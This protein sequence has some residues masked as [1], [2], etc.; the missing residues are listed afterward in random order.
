MPE[1]RV[2]VNLDNLTLGDFT[3][4]QKGRLMG[5]IGKS[6][7]I[8]GWKD[9]GDVPISN[10]PQVTEALLET[11]NAIDLANMIS[12]IALDDISTQDIDKMTF[13]DMGEIENGNVDIFKKFIVV[14]DYED[15]DNVPFKTIGLIQ[16]TLS[17]AISL[18]ANP[19]S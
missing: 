1:I 19:N 17:D 14:K 13:R 11:I 6:V 5:I 10:L 2:S 16:Q 12:P 4:L 9:V 18:A 7:S 8:Q 3:A 15:I